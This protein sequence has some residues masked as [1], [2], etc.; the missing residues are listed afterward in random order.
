MPEA[1]KKLA[2]DKIDLTGGGYKPLVGGWRLSVEERKK[3][4]E[5]AMKFLWQMGKGEIAGYNV[6]E[7]QDTL[8]ATLH[9][10]DLAKMALETA[11][12]NPNRDTQ[13]WLANVF[14]DPAFDKLKLTT[15]TGA[16][17]AHSQKWPLPGKAPHRQPEGR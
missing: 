2:D 13:L 11:A 8:R 10:P 3:F 15:I 5:D 7:A 6:R 12:L 9:K 16:A 17:A 14:F 1:L 4:S